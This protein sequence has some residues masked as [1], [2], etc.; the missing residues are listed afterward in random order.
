MRYPLRYLNLTC[1]PC[2]SCEDQCVFDLTTYGNIHFPYFV[3][4]ISLL[5]ITT[6]P[7]ATYITKL[8]LDAEYKNVSI[9]PSQRRYYS[10]H[11]PA[12]TEDYLSLHVTQTPTDEATYMSLIAL[13]K[14]RCPSISPYGTQPTPY[15]YCNA[16]TSSSPISEMSLTRPTSSVYDGSKFIHKFFFAYRGLQKGDYFIRIDGCSD[17]NAH[18]CEVMNYTLHAQVRRRS[19][20]V[21]F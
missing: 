3:F 1:I 7:S 20:E 19:L 5:I 8:R 16:N 9:L 10:F 6:T 14:D 12:P 17:S 2:P 21:S 11:V 4:H 18:R 13:Q 15:V